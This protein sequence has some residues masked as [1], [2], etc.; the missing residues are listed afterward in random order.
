MNI[1]YLSLQCYKE[2]LPWYGTTIKCGHSQRNS[3]KDAENLCCLLMVH[4]VSLFFSFRSTDSSKLRWGYFLRLVRAPPEAHKSFYNWLSSTADEWN[5][6]REQNQWRLVALIYRDL[7]KKKKSLQY[8]PEVIL[9]VVLAELT[10]LTMLICR[11]IWI[12][13]ILFIY[14]YGTGWWWRHEQYSTADNI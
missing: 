6:H 10:V 8:N 11:Y 3:I 12:I 9:L 4:F 14:F 7:K 13:E 5:N 2:I 1:Q